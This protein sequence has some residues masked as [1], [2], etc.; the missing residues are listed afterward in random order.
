VSAVMIA[1]SI[2]ISFALL[3]RQTPLCLVYTPP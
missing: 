1:V 2:A 3:I